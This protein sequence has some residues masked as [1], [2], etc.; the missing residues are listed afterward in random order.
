MIRSHQKM[1]TRRYTRRDLKRPI[2]FALVHTP[3]VRLFRPATVG[4][5]TVFVLHRFG[6]SEAR[7]ASTSVEHLRATLAYLRRNHYQLLSLEEVVRSFAGDGPPLRKAVAFT[8]DDGYV[9]QATVGAPVFAEFDCPVSMFLTTGFLDG[10]VV[11]WW[12]AV[13]HV[14]ENTER[15]GIRFEVGDSNVA[16]SWSSIDDRFQAEMD[17]LARCK[18]IPDVERR[19][20]IGEL[21]RAADVAVPDHPLSPNLPMTWDQARALERSGVTFGPHT[22]SHPILSRV[23]AEVAER[24]ITESWRRLQAELE[25]P[26][27]VFCYPNGRRV[28]FGQREVDVARRIGMAGALTVDEARAVPRRGACDPGA[29]FRI[30][31]IGFPTDPLDALFCVSGLDRVQRVL[32]SRSSEET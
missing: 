4:T 16:Y 20:A 5:V 11:P 21:A 29:E 25:R 1:R 13:Q 2:G 10:T 12:D 30:S 14:F 32:S 6:V 7:H 26:M 27:P 23:D 31:R 15:A 9:D 28:D 19:A 24:E 3:A 8:V 17:F 18:D 22:V